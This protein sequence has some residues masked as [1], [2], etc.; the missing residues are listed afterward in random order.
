M[1]N[2]V[3]ISKAQSQFYKD[4]YSEKLNETNQSCKDSLEIFLKNTKIP[5][6]SE[7]QNNLCDK[8]ITEK[9]ILESIKNLAT[10][11]TPRSDG[12]PAE[13]FINSVGLTSNPYYVIIFIMLLLIELLCYH[14]K[15]KIISTTQRVINEINNIVQNCIW[16]FN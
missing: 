5:K 6:L 4:L 2:P 1:D 10:G 15:G 16:E 11:K 14:K 9:E 13:F 8:P 7:E 3:D 12:L